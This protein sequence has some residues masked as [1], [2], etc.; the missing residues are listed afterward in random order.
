MSDQVTDLKATMPDGSIVFGE[1]EIDALKQYPEKI[2]LTRKVSAPSG[3]VNAILDADIIVIGPGSL[4]SSVLPPLLVDDIAQAVQITSACKV[5]IENIQKENSVMSHFSNIEAVD[6]IE[7]MVGFQ[8]WD[9]SLSP[10]AL[11]E[12]DLAANEHSTSPFHSITSLNQLFSDLGKP[13]TGI[14]NSIKH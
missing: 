10:E 6:W 9:I 4:I 13:I 2:E 14:N 3:V 12:L 8:F 5:L 7:K 11:V 1:V